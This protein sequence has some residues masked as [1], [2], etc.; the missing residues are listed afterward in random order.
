M[1]RPKPKK[2]KE[3][4]KKLERKKKGPDPCRKDL[5]PCTWPSFVIRMYSKNSSCKAATGTEPKVSQSE[6]ILDSYWTEHV[7]GM[8]NL[9]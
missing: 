2:S 7:V 1:K 4:E 3:W 6:K 8:W 5:S 9:F